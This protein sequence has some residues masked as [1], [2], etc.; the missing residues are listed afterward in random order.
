MKYVHLHTHSHYSLLD[1]LGKI[2]QLLTRAK[3]LNM[4]SL[5]LTDHGVMYGIIEFYEAA[6]AMDIKPIL[7]VEAYIAPRRLT[8]KSSREDGKP[9]HLVLLAES[10][11]G[12]RNL[13]KLVSIA[14]KEG[15]ITSHVSTKK[16]SK[17]TAV[18]LLLLLPASSAKCRV[19]SQP[20]T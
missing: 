19:W 13:L 14:H 10:F 20:R 17:N 12:Y 1:G 5:A 16:C 8:D 6:K 11:E 18:A 3:E 4:D 15:T 9:Y 2:D 7:G